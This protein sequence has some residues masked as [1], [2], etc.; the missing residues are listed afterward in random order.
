MT[1]I[2]Y[3]GEMAAERSVDQRR[4]DLCADGIAVAR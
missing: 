2:I 4:L 1:F 3:L